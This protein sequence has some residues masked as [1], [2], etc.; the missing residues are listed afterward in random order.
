MLG[1]GIRLINGSFVGTEFL[2][3]YVRS[4]LT[5]FWFLHAM[6]FSVLLVLFV[7]KILG[8]RWR[9]VYIILGMMML[10]IPS[11]MPNIYLY[12]FL[13]P[14]FVAGFLVNDC[15]MMFQLTEKYKRL[16][17]FI[18]GIIFIALFVL[19]D[20]KSYI[21]ISGISLVKDNAIVFAQLPIDLYRWFIG[22][23][24]SMLILIICH[25]IYNYWKDMR[26]IN[27]IT[28]IGQISLGIYI[29]N[30][31]TN[32]YVLPKLTEHAKPGLLIWILETFVELGGYFIF[33][34]TVRKTSFGNKFLLGGR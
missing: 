15:T 13:Y 22:F 34:V 9:Y 18:L 16:L 12:I 20:Y 10:F 8:K 29:L 7:E 17:F 4:V 25:E 31:Y 3:G 21:Y 1:G 27:C 30:T 19:Y 6:F 11:D 24:G 14:Y 26:I 32:I 33:I 5:A 28:R 23:I 2:T